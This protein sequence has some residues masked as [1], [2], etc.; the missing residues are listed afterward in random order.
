MN[1]LCPEL[2]IN[3]AAMTNVDLCEEKM[4]EAYN[5]NGLA[6]KHIVRLAMK[7]GSYLVHVSTDYVF[8]GFSGNYREES[9]PNPIN[10]YGLSKLVGDIFV[11][12]Y[13]NSLIVRT[14]GVY[15]YLNNFPAF[16]YNALKAGKSLTAIEDH[17]SP[18]HAGNLA[19]SITY[20]ANN[21]L[22][23][24]INVA[25]QRISR[26]EF[27]RAI[28]KYFELDPGLI[29]KGKLSST[30]KAKR[31]IDSSLDIERAKK[32]IPYDFYSLDSNLKLFSGTVNLETD[33]KE[34]N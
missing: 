2:I 29:L 20:C 26:F 33:R 27:A 25:G 31:P 16:A 15:G 18:I 10:F 32:L 14:S 34:L 5:V 21:R 24:T 11:S 17:Y 4:D 13:E 9:V 1:E 12:S 3:A 22:L 7:Y 8:D 19:K 30:M 23:G 28:A 6:L